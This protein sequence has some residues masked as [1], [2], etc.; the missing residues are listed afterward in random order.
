MLTPH[1]AILLVTGNAFGSGAELATD[2]LY[3]LESCGYALVAASEAEGLRNY[4]AEDNRVCNRMRYGMKC[5]LPTGHSGIHV[6]NAE[7]E[8]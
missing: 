1:E 7:R 5:G 4:L 6:S 2:I 8:Q 3:S